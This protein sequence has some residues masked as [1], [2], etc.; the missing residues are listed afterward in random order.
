MFKKGLYI[1]PDNL[2]SHFML[3]NILKDEGNTKAAMIHYR[4][5]MD[6]TARIKEEEVERLFHGMNIK[7]LREFISKFIDNSL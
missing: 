6:I 7:R 4:N 2:L 3:G 5:A 1:N